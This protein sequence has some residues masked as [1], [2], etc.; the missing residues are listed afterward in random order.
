[1]TTF[2]IIL[3]IH[4]TLVNIHSINLNLPLR[5]WLHK[6]LD[7]VT[8][9][10][11][12]KHQ[13]D[14]VYFYFSSASDF[15][16]NALLLH[17]LTNYGP[18]AGYVNCFHSY[19]TNRLSLENSL[20]F[21]CSDNHK[22]LGITNPWY[23]KSSDEI[24]KRFYCFPDNFISLLSL[25]LFFS[26]SKF[27]CSTNQLAGSRH[28]IPWSEWACNWFRKLKIKINILNNILILYKDKNNCTQKIN[29]VLDINS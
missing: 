9:S 23:L 28:Y 14:A 6:Y 12:S 16:P 21:Y 19:L 11:C 4:W 26:G 18:S 10:V 5:I 17:K 27:Y 8:P 7:F 2:L 13:A 20:L 1:M 3:C 24:M 29:S 22:R 15:I 25:S